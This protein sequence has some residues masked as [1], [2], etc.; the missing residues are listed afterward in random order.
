VLIE[1]CSTQ[2]GK[3]KIIIAKNSEEEL[4]LGADLRLE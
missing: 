1:K 4:N 2:I 3:V